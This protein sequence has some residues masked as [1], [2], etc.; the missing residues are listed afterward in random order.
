M[1]DAAQIHAKLLEGLALQQTGQFAQAR[2]IYRQILKRDPDNFDALHLLGVIAA[3]TR[4]FAESVELI[5]RAIDVNPHNPTAHYNRGIAFDELR[6]YEAAVAAYDKAIKLKPDHAVAYNNRGVA[7]TLSRLLTDAVA[8]FDYAIALHPG[9]ADA[10]YNRGHALVDMGRL[11][12]ALADFDEALRLRP[13]YPFLPGV[14]LHTKMRVCDWRNAAQ[15]IAALEARLAQS[16]SVSTPW[17]ILALTDSQELQYN[18]AHVWARITHPENTILGG[19]ARHTRRGKIRIGYFSMDFRDHPVAQLTARM[20]ELHDRT[21]F[22]IYAFSYGP[23]V[24]DEMRKRLR[25]AF[26]GFLDVHKKSDEDIAT[27][28]REMR[29]DIAVDLAGYTTGARP[30]IMAVR[31]APIQVNYLGYAGSMAVPYIDYIVADRFVIPE[32]NRRYFSE[33]VAELPCYMANDDTRVISERIFSREDAGLPPDGFVFCCFNATHKILPATFAGWMRILKQV[34][35]SVLWLAHA[36]PTAADNLRRE[37]EHRGVNPARLI[38]A[39]RLTAP[40]DHLARHRLAD[41]SLDTLPFN[42]HTTASDALWAGVP[43]LTCPGQSF[44]GRVG[45]SLL[46]AIGLP[47]LVTS[48]QEAFEALAV[49][50]ATQPAQ[51]QALKDRLRDHR[52][53]RP[54]F[55]TAWFARRMEAVYIRMI[56]QHEAGLPPEHF[57]VTP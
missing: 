31:A 39:E 44:A 7:L 6:Q 14:R 32:D 27:L 22:E 41:L 28:A 9:Y 24:N 37:A 4:N 21:N 49:A 17:P 1:S 50:L 36:A 20:F 48:S 19:I 55:D 10:Y 51:L 16:E 33:K 15:D 54:L 18:A 43:H 57:A 38:F 56:E 25:H 23:D 8:S 5:G 29:I 47:E 11:D 26:D 45:G 46:H 42:A 40:A 53:T 2:D 35:N 52:T 12:E 30:G 34:E 13:D 3:Q